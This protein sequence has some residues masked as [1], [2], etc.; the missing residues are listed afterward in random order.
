MADR[1][2]T[3][4]P[5]MIHHLVIEQYVGVMFLRSSSRQ[6]TIRM[7]LLPHSTKIAS[8]FLKSGPISYQ[9]QCQFPNSYFKKLAQQYFCHIL[10]V[11]QSQSIMTQGEGTQTSHIQKEGRSETWRP[12]FKPIIPRCHV[13]TTVKCYL[14]TFV[15]FYLRPCYLIESERIC[16]FTFNPSIM[17]KPFFAGMCDLGI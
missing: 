5:K 17:N 9:I 7:S 13:I 14:H 8:N 1:M 11:K 12:Y 2:L 3:G 4:V 16:I 10:L 6:L 15:S